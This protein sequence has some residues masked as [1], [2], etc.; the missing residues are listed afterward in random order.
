MRHRR[1]QMLDAAESPSAFDN[2]RALVQALLDAGTPAEVL[3]DDLGQIRGLVTS[4][5]E[6]DVL[7]VMDLLT[8]WCA[9]GVALRP[10][11]ESGS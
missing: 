6:E 8:G 2:L 10:R 4:D 5:Q 11:G 3:L 7:D 9:P 1:D